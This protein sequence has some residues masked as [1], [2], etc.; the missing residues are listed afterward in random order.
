MLSLLRSSLKGNLLKQLVRSFK[1]HSTIN[2]Q[3]NGMS[4]GICIN[5]ERRH[6]EEIRDLEEIRRKEEEERKRRKEDSLDDF[7]Y[8]S[9]PNNHTFTSIPETHYH[10]YSSNYSPSSSFDNEYSD[11]N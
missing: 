8:I 6:A 2:Y 1:S 7:I 11:D 10:T 3:F 5:S 4:P 9:Q